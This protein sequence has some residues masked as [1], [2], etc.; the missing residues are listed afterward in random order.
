MDGGML[1]RVEY[2][3]HT[4]RVVDIEAD[5]IE[6]ARRLWFARSDEMVDEI[7]D[8]SVEVD[9]GEDLDSAEFSVL[10]EDHERA[11]LADP[12]MTDNDRDAVIAS[13]YCD[14]CETEG[15][16]FRQCSKRDDDFDDEE[17]E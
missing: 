10:Y 16:P 4:T 8:S 1:I 11:M 15:H 14:Y 12:T 6:H 17:A 3:E 13:D 5:D 7:D 9:G 2:R